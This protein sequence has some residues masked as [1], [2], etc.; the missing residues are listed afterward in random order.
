MEHFIQY[1]FCIIILTR[2]YIPIDTCI[3][4]IEPEVTIGTIPGCGGSQRLTRAVGKSKAMEMILTG[5]SITADEAK[6]YNLVSRVVPSSELIDNAVS[7]GNKIASYSQPIIQMAKEAVNA[8]YDTTLQ[9]GVLFER[10]LFHS[11]FGT[12]DQ[13]HGMTSFTKKQKPQWTNN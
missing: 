7:L 6:Q 4:S 10:R 3:L 1:N 13:K 9:Q 8:A 2:Y 5:E 12:Q 11:T